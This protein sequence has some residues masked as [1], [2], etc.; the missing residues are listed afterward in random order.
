MTTVEA[1]ISNILPQFQRVGHD[2][3]SRGLVSSHSG[4]LSIRAGERLIITRQGSM[5]AHLSEQDLVDT[6]FH[7]VWLKEMT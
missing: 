3:F 1:A 6:C 5:L 2:L 4:N 7:Q